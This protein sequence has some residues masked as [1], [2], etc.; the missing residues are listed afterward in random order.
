MFYFIFWFGFSILLIRA[1]FS[2]VS[3]L[4]SRWLSKSTLSIGVCLSLTMVGKMNKFINSINR[5]TPDLRVL[6]YRKNINLGVVDVRNIFDSLLTCFCNSESRKFLI[7]L[8]SDGKKNLSGELNRKVPSNF[9]FT[10]GIN[11]ISKF[12]VT[13]FYL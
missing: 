9:L 10:K 5:E 6:S 4:G 8:I 11:L 12:F 3:S 1:L 2:D 7:L 13:F